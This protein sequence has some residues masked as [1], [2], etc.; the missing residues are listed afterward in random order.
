MSSDLVFLGPKVKAGLTGG[1]QLSLCLDREMDAWMEV[2]SLWAGHFL[3]AFPTFSL[4]PASW[5]TL[6]LRAMNASTN[7]FLV[8][9]LQLH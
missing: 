7:G 5:R 2:C 9:S 4:F 6:W 1:F 3:L 8:F